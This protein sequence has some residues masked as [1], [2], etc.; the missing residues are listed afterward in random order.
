MHI[1]RRKQR[2]GRNLRTVEYKAA[3]VTVLLARAVRLAG[4]SRPASWSIQQD[5]HE[6]SISLLSLSRTFT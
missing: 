4:A 1:S 6:S 2:R 5:F 3:G